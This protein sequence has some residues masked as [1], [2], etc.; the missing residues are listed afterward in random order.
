MI[1]ITKEKDS[2]GQNVIYVSKCK[3]YERQNQDLPIYIANRLHKGEI[4]KNPRLYD[5]L[6]CV[7]DYLYNSGK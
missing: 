7:E 4:H 1:E 5:I 2:W 6:F 3:R